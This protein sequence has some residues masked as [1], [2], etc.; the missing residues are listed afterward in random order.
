ML[1]RENERLGG[2]ARW[3]MVGSASSYMRN[4][5]TQEQDG[6]NDRDGQGRSCMQTGLEQYETQD[7]PISQNRVSR[8]ITIPK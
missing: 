3:A 7:G 6:R 5:H 8:I 2:F 4:T 1:P